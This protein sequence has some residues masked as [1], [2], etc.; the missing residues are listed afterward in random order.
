[1]FAPLV[2]TLVILGVFI[3]LQV[4]LDTLRGRRLKAVSRQLVEIGKQQSLTSVSVVVREKGSKQQLINLLDHLASFSYAKLQVVVVPRS[5]KNDRSS[6][7]IV[8]YRA[9]HSNLNIRIVRSSGRRDDT[10][11][12]RRHARGE[13][14]LWMSTSERLTPRFF[15]RLSYEF[16]DATIDQ[17]D[18]PYRY[19][20]A[21]SVADLLATWSTIR[22]E[23]LGLIWRRRRHSRHPVYRRASYKQSGKQFLVVRPGTPLAFIRPRQAPNI[24]NILVVAVNLL[25]ATA[26][27]YAVFYYV[28]TQWLFTV[29]AVASAYLLSNLFWLASSKRYTLPEA[30]SLVLALP[31]AIAGHMTTVFKRR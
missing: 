26:A 18:I 1:M 4:A 24:Q 29:L 23:A 9:S 15:E 12:A 11:V 30:V 7:Y 22:S 17:V 19:E 31:Y 13:L 10:S 2:A 25:V 20:T 6:R 16:A 8:D 21:R 28:S 3:I 14:V 27:G 5:R